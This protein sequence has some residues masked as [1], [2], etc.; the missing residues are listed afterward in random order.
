[1]ESV[2]LTYSVGEAAEAVGVGRTFMFD[3]IRRGEIRSFK[4]GKRRLVPIA[5]LHEWVER[6]TEVAG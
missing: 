4:A 6:Q 5:A 3:L 1:M 2:R